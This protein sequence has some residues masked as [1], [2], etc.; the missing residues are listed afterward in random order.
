MITTNKPFQEWG[1]IFTDEVI[2]SAILDRL[3]HHCFPFFITGPSYR[4]KELFQKTYDSQTNK[5]TN[6]NKKT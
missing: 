3:F 4:T 6:S 2:A 5:D 1:E